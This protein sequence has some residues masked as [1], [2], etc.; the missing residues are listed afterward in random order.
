MDEDQEMERFEMDN[1]FEEGQWINGE[2]Y[3]KKR[4]EK[5]TQTRDDVLYG[6]FAGS[7]DDDDDDY[8]SKK[9]RKDLSKK[10]DLT[11]PCSKVGILFEIHLMGWSWY[12]RGRLSLML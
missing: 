6:V 11:K 12:L 7:D 10:Q 5:R 8:S 4:K 1:D 3:Y 9:L 2:F